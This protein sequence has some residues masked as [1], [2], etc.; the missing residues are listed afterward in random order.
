MRVS[1]FRHH[2]IILNPTGQLARSG[3]AGHIPQDRQ[4]PRDRRTP[5]E[6]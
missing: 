5:Q 3:E 4:A 2:T 6:R 1:S